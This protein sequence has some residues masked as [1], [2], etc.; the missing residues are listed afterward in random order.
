MHLI[1]LSAVLIGRDRFRAIERATALLIEIAGG[2]AGPVLNTTIESEFPAVS[3][4]PL[5]S[6]RVSRVL[7]VTIPDAEISETL[8]TI[9][10]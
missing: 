10:V 7:G 4:V 3:V 9:R 1:G 6:Q 2:E 8:E 5:R